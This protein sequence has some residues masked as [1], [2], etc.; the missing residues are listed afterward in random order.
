MAGRP[1]KE[2]Q[3]LINERNRKMLSMRKNGYPITYIAGV[4]NLSKGRASII[5]TKLIKMEENEKRQ[6]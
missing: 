4:F 2:H 1:K 3:N 6:K 5:L